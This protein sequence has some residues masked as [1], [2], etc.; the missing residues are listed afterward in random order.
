MTNESHEPI[1]PTLPSDEDI[2][3]RFEKIREELKSFEL[4]NLTEEEELQEKLQHVQSAPTISRM[5]EVPELNIPKRN[6]TGPAKDGTPG[7]YNYRGLGVGMSAAYSLIGAMI[8][9]YGLGWGYDKLFHANYGQ[10]IGALI[11][12]VLGIA[13]A[14]WVINKDSG[15]TK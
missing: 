3:A 4:P 11:G 10:V 7:N 9:G 13:S 14:I 5:P 8:V 12:S 1:K 15:D 2:Q 6:T